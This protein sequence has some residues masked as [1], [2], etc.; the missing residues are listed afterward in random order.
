MNKNAISGSGGCFQAGTSVATPTGYINIEDINIGDLVVSFDDKGNLHTSKVLSTHIHYNFDIY[1]YSLW[2]GNKIAATSNHWVLT[3]ENFFCQIGE[4]NDSLALVNSSNLLVPIIDSRYIGKGTVY[5]LTVEKYHTY[6]ANNIRVHNGGGGKGSKTPV[7]S[8]DTLRSTSYAFVLD[9][10][11]EGEIEGFAKEDADQCIYI[12]NTPLKNSSGTYNF[13]D[14]EYTLRTGTPNQDYIPGFDAIESPGNT[15]SNGKI[16]K[17]IPKVVS[18]PAVIVDRVRITIGIPSLSE[19]K[20]N[21]DTTGAEVSYT[22]EVSKNGG[23]YYKEIEKTLSGKCSSRYQF[24]HIVVLNRTADTDYFDIKVSR[25]T[26]DSTSL[27]LQNEIWLDGTTLITDTKLVYPHTALCGVKIAS[28]QFNSVPTRGYHLKLMKVKMPSNYTPG[29]VIRQVEFIPTTDKIKDVGHTFLNGQQIKTLI[30]SGTEPSLQANTTYYIVNKEVDYYQLSST[31]NGSPIN[32]TSP[33]T[34]TLGSIVTIAQYTGIWDGQLTN[35]GWTNNPAWCFYDLLTDKRYGLGEYIPETLVDK[36]ALYSISQYCDFLVPDGSGGMEPR[37]TLNTYIQT[38]EDAIKLVMDMASVFRGMVYYAEGGI[39]VSQDSNSDSSA[40]QFTNSNVYNGVF[41]YSGASRKVIHTAALVTWNDPKALYN[42]K[43]EYVEDREAIERYGYNPSDIIAFGCTSRGQANRLGKWLLYTEKVESNIVSFKAG[44]DAGFCRPGQIIKIFDEGIA[45]VPYS[46]RLLVRNDNNTITLDRDV[47]L[48]TTNTYNIRFNIIEE[49]DG[50]E[51]VNTVEYLVINT[52]NNPTNTIDIFGSLH[53]S[54]TPNT[55]WSISSSIL[56][57]DLY[58]IV[59]IKE[60]DQVGMYDISAMKHK[61]GKFDYIENDIAFDENNYSLVTGIPG[62]IPYEDIHYKQGVHTDQV[63]KLKSPYL[64]VSYKAPKYAVKYDI[65]FKR[66][67][68]N[69]E[70]STQGTPALEHTIYN[71]V[72]E[73]YYSIRVTPINSLNQRGPSTTFTDIFIY[74]SEAPLPLVS[75]ITYVIEKNYIHFEWEGPS[76]DPNFSHYEV[77]VNET[78]ET[79]VLGYTDITTKFLDYYTNNLIDD[80]LDDTYKFWFVTVNSLGIKSAATLVSITLQG[81]DSITSLTATGATEAIDLSWVLPVPDTG[82]VSTEIYYST[83]NDRNAAIPLSVTAHPLTNYL[84]TLTNP[85][86]HEFYYWGRTVDTLGFKSVWYPSGINSGV[87]G[88]ALLKPALE[89]S[90]EIL[91]YTGFSVNAGGLP[92]PT[93]ATLTASI[94]NIVDPTYL[95]SIDPIGCLQSAANESTC[96]IS[97]TANIVSITV[98]LTVGGKNSNG[99]P[100]V[101]PIVKTI[102]M[103]VV[104][105]GVPGQAGQ[106]GMMSAFPTIYKWTTNT[107]APSRPTTQS[108]YIWATGAYTAPS[109]W[110]VEA[111]T[112]LTPGSILWRITIPLTTT[113]STVSSIL[114]WT[115]IDY[116]IVSIAKNGELGPPGPAGPPGSNGNGP[117]SFILDRVDQNAPTPTEVTTK[118]GR[119]AIVGDIVTVRYGNNETRIFEYLPSGWIQQILRINGSLIVEN[120]ITAAKLSVTQL[121]AI[122]ANLG[123]ITSGFIEGAVISGSLLI[124][125]TAAGAPY[126]T[127]YLQQHHKAPIATNFS[128]TKGTTSVLT[129]ATN[130]LFIKAYNSSPTGYSLTNLNRCYD[131]SL[132]IVVNSTFTY[133]GRTNQG[134]NEMYITLQVMNGSS[135]IATLI[136]NLDCSTIPNGTSTTINGLVIKPPAL[137]W[138]TNEINELVPSSSDGSITGT[139]YINYSGSDYIGGVYLKLTLTTWRGTYGEGSG[140][141]EFSTYTHGLL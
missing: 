127:Y 131:S 33:Y 73:E 21:G 110:G 114:D 90:V 123:H 8:P 85:A 61:P 75:D 78:Y 60:S 10:L 133:S 26:E 44:L 129:C 11:C 119:T 132:P 99:I 120:T 16:L 62:M 48:N 4:I 77:T 56:D 63:T 42:Q 29:G 96:V 82:I 134:F 58:R 93:S 76:S 140:T 109:T 37:F 68:G 54:I 20:D 3:S 80:N 36:W 32:I 69:W 40:I 111:P 45:Y 72:S 24:S 59:S 124:R 51:V 118:L 65:E 22:I 89:P 39:S 139:A 115:K 19:Y 83:T 31:F 138:Y 9:A 137:A 125:P 98:T 112:N 102:T 23:P 108:T 14:Y 30:V 57:E 66:G 105:N 86:V 35:Y 46:G 27:K 12:N 13:T 49:V 103:P 43:I 128:G 81:P 107:T 47:T 71:L 41:E 79:S 100:L 25:V 97:P 1:E 130:A 106:H 70:F 113:A 121:S 6:I 18:I 91:G 84:H 28:E 136:N 67:T 88:I 101:T 104:Y 117:V 17:D 7:N 2:G 87:H 15:A 141:L 74:I 55:V 94:K 34:T 92:T 64:T 135:V 50:K 53:T 122:T 116:D 95:W 52:T 5:N 126:Y 38:K